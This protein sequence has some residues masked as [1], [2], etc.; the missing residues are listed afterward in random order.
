MNWKV[1]ILEREALDIVILTNFRLV[2]GIL[3]YINFFFAG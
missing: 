2:V 1:A 3:T